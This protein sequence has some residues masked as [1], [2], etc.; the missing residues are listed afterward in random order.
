MLD[1]WTTALRMTFLQLAVIL[2]LEQNFL[3]WVSRRVLDPI[4]VT[5]AG[6]RHALDPETWAWSARD[7]RHP[8]G[9]TWYCCPVQRMRWS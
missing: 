9:L 1:F 4:P 3:E 8:R 5:C 6:G 7:P 2:I